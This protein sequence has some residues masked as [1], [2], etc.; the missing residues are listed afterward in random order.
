[1]DTRSG[2]R[3]R[4]RH[5]MTNTRFRNFSSARRCH[6]LSSRKEEKKKKKEK[7]WKSLAKENRT[8]PHLTYP[9]YP[10]GVFDLWYEN[11]YRLRTR[12]HVDV[13][14]QRQF[15]QSMTN[16]KERSGYSDSWGSFLSLSLSLSFSQS[17][18]TANIARHQGMVGSFFPPLS[19]K[20]PYIFILFLTVSQK[21]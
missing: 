18:R 5:G 7:E 8:R 16:T 1:M 14:V 11:W 4:K 19:I 3:Q 9:L 12:V 6:N 13:T 20:L 17:Q 2:D 15:R 10:R 21:Y